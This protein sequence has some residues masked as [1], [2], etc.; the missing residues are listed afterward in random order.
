M[1][2]TF[3]DEQRMMAG[4]LRELLDDVCTPSAVR[5]AAEGA[6]A[7]RIARWPK[8]AE[9]GLAGVL[10][11]ESAGGI[12]LGNVS[13]VLLAEAA[14]RAALPEMLIEHA[15]VA[16]PALAGLAQSQRAAAALRDAA[17]GAAR[18]AVLHPINPFA[19]AA[20]EADLFL[21]FDGDAVHLLPRAQV[22]LDALASL[23]P[24]RALASVSFEASS[25]TRIASG[26]AARAASDAARERGALYAAAELLGLAAKLI[27]I[28]VEYTAQRQQ[29]GKAIG[30]YQAVKHHLANAQ[31]KLE[32]ARPVVYAAAALLEDESDRARLMVSHAKLSAAEAAD[33]AARMAMQV[34]GAMGYSW[35]V[36]LHFFMKRAFVLAGWYGDR[37]FH[38]RRVQSLIYSDLLPIGPEF[39]FDRTS[40]HG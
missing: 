7:L 16:V 2:F 17:S 34:H 24:V 19:M 9:M 37:N 30:S 40:A 14:G 25:D 28:A 32:F 29:F 10:A 12:G 35:E 20:A 18:I 31:V 27:E 38:M 39:T 1:D 11:P 4:A 3:S 33:F 8:L 6:G 36:D 13:F 5:A 15:G 21:M 26:A 23:D 22:K